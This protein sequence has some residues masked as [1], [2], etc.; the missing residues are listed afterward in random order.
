MSRKKRS[1]ADRPNWLFCS[2]K[3]RTIFSNKKRKLPIIMTNI[4][5]KGCGT[6]FQRKTQRTYC[7]DVCALQYRNKHNNPAKTKEAK[8]KLSDFARCRGVAHMR[9]PEAIKKMKETIT[10][11]GHW[12]WQGG[13][14]CKNKILRNRVDYKTWIKSV[15]LRDDF[16]CQKCGERGGHL[17]VDHIKPFAFYPELRMDY[18]NVRTLCKK[19]HKETDTYMGRAYAHR[20]L[21][22]SG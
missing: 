21:A 20:L 1:E 11:S 8:N 16:T 18:T 3:C 5:C 9:T 2:K 14:T 15:L 7:S 6:L 13:L 4:V 10:G 22:K 17:E 19:C 12:N